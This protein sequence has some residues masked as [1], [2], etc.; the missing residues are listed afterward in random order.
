[1]NPQGYANELLAKTSLGQNLMFKE[2]LSSMPI[3]K[4]KEMLSD[5]DVVKRLTKQMLDMI[6]DELSSPNR[7]LEQ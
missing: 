6:E 2:T 5:P 3:E 1:L 4:I 7:R